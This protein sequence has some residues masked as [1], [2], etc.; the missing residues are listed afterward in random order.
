MGG[1]GMF[2]N[3]LSIQLSH[4]PGEDVLAEE[5]RPRKN[6]RVALYGERPGWGEDFP[7]YHSLFLRRGSAF[8]G[9]G[10]TG[11]PDWNAEVI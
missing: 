5:Y 8:V 11:K 3:D 4:R 2:E 10:E 7:I 9:E 6:M 1:G